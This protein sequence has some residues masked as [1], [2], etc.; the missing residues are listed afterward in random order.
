MVRQVGADD[1]GIFSFRYS[2]ACVINGL[3]EAVRTPSACFFEPQ[4]IS[5]SRDWVNHGC[6]RSGIR[7]DDNILAE[8]PLEPQS[9]YAKAG[10]LIGEVEVARIV[11]RLGHSPRHVSLRT[12]FNL[13]THNQFVR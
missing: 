7:C 6:K 5:H 12:V 9:G 11:R 3:V 4:K 13:T 8:A 10:V 1:G 2:L